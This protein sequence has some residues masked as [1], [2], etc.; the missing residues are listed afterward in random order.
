MTASAPATTASRAAWALPVAVLALSTVGVVALAA[1]PGRQDTMA[2]VYPPWWSPARAAVS[3]AAEGDLTAVGGA[4][5]IL[6]IHSDKPELGR[7]LRR[8]G[9]L[10]LIDSS[11]A[12]LCAAP[13]DRDAS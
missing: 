5:T 2:A 8:S 4:A 1:A 11:L 13:T 6:V 10:L 9:A 3:A 7:R 12:S